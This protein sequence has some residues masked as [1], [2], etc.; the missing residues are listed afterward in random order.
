MNF[1]AYR[2]AA[3]KGSLRRFMTFDHEVTLRQDFTDKLDL[4]QKAVD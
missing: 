3:A 2:S 4:L 1:H